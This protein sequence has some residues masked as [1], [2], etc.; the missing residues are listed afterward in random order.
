MMKITKIFLLVSLAVLLSFQGCKYE[1]GP[2]LSLS[3]KKNRAVNKWVIDKVYEKGVDNTE[4]YKRFF[5]NYSIELKSDKNYVLKYRPFNF[6]DYE[7]K[8]TWDFSG[9]KKQ[10]IFKPT[11]QSSGSIWNILRLKSNEA[12]VTQLVD[13]EELELHMKD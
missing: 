7:E 1:E 3:S 11:D 10:I 5:V 2:M 9:D 13:G 4:E 12:W 6:S 8:G